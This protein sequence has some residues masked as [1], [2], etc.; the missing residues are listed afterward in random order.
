MSFKW[1]MMLALLWLNIHHVLAHSATTLLNTLNQLQKHTPLIQLDLNTF[2]NIVQGPRN[3]SV[4]VT[5]TALHPDY[6]CHLCQAF[7]NEYQLLAA[8]WQKLRIPNQL[9]FAYLDYVSGSSA[10]QKVSSKAKL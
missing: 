4:Y 7:H 10:F 5:M 2:E 8:A 1:L 6:N 9:F 3:F